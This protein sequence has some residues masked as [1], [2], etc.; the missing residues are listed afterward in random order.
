MSKPLPYT[1][2]SIARRIQ[3]VRKAG[4]HA[5]GVTSD[6]TILIGDRPLDASS[7]TAVVEQPSPVIEADTRRMGDYF[8]GG[9]SETQGP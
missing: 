3:G 1:Q 9:S 7:L 2:A 8:D 4:L 5:L 6:G